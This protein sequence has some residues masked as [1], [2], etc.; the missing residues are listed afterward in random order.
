M[1]WLALGP[2]LQR[3]WNEL[4]G[5]DWLDVAWTARKMAKQK[6]DRARKLDGPRART[7]AEW[8]R[9]KRRDP[10]WQEREKERRARVY[11]ERKGKVHR[12]ILEIPQPIWERIERVCALKK[13]NKAALIRRGIMLILPIVERSLD[14]R[15]AS[16]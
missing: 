11:A 3:M 7:A 1:A 9:E 13:I 6:Y 2:E 12:F 14:D 10:K 5:R 16:P 8:R 15:K 4:N